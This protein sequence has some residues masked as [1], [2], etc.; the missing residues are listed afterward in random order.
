M[1]ASPGSYG[2]LVHEARLRRAQ[3][4]AFELVLGG[5]DTFLEL[6][7]LALRVAQILVSP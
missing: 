3:V 4:D 6:G 2:E 5:G 7:D 1:I